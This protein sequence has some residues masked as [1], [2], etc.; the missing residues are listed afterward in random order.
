MR[1]IVALTLFGALVA[2][3]ALAVPPTVPELLP[4]VPQEAQVVVAVD[5]AALRTHPLV[6]GWLLDHADWS[7]ADAAAARFLAEA[8]L[9]PLRDVTAMVVA[10]VPSGSHGDPVV[11]LAGRFDAPAIAAA[12]TKRGATPVTLGT[13][14]G[15][16]LPEKDRAGA[17]AVLAQPS[18]ELIVVGS[19]ALVAES[20]SVKGSTNPLVDTAVG[21]G[22][23]DPRA[24]FWAVAAIS[25]EARQKAAD[26]ASRIQGDSGEPLRQ[27]VMATGVV[28]KVAVQ[29]FLD[30]SLRL[31]GVAVA[32][33]AE[34][35]ELLRDTVKGVLAAARLH[36]QDR[37]P[38]LVGVLR[39]VQ[40]R[41]A[42]SQV[43]LAGAV[44]V[45]LIEKLIAEHK[46]NHPCDMASH[47]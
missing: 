14:S 22:Q 3:A 16:R 4:L 46:A 38:E 44:P 24:P 15:L 23:V 41:A 12:L 34:N 11:F 32:D 26:A 10:L 18:P 6:Q 17:A 27:A 9:D 29:A 7:N 47:S 25:A 8:G 5:A 13:V 35:A 2:G 43:T 31:S 1:K 21:S 33:T 42:G 28:Q 36:C 40:V 39:D 19:E 37:A 20:L 30:D 45:A